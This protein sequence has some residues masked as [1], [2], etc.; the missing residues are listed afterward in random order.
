MEFGLIEKNI[1][2]LLIF[3]ILYYTLSLT[4]QKAFNQPLTLLDSFYFAT[5]TQSTVGY[6]DIHPILPMSK[7]VVCA[8]IKITILVNIAHVIQHANNT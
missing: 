2:G 8:H 4:N 5:T 1:I 6:G 7:L 3:T